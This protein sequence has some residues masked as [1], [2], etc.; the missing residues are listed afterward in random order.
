MPPVFLGEIG[1]Q[2]DLRY[3]GVIDQRVDMV[4]AAQNFADD[5]VYARPVGNVAQEV[6]GIAAFGAQFI[7]KH[8]GCILPRPAEKDCAPALAREQLHAGASDAARAA[9]DE[10]GFRHQ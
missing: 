7:R 3:G 1:K 10:Y 4:T 6:F 2:L 9:G 5:L 8:F